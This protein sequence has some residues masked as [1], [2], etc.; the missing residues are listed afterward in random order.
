M[1][2]KFYCGPYW[3]PECIQKI[4]SKHFNASC[5]IHDMDYASKQYDQNHADRRFLDNMITQCKGRFLLEVLACGYFIAVRI[6][7]KLSWKKDVK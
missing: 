1:A 3:M 6:G 5:K 4:M 7:G 2:N